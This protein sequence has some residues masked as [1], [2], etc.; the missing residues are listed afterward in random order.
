MTRRDRRRAAQRFGRRAE[1][2]CRW[3][4][5]LCG[6]RILAQNWRCPGGEIDIVAQRRSIIAFIEVKARAGAAVETAAPAPHQRR[7]IERA[8]EMFLARNPRLGTLS[9]RFDLMVVRPW[10]GFRF[11][12]PVHLP[13]AWRSSPP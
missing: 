6:W 12:W 3:R 4:L 2:L 10:P 8:A 11:L 7:R 1:W 9:G 5:R 13:D